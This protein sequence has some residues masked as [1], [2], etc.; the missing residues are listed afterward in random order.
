MIGS[1]ESS[2]PVSD[3]R[4]LAEAIYV[5]SYVEW[6]ILDDL[7]RLT[8]PPADLSIEG[9]SRS[10]MGHV[11]AA[12]RRASSGATNGAESAWLGA[13]ADALEAVV[14]RRNRVVHAHPATIA[15][16]QM[17]F[18]WATATPTKPHEAEAITQRDLE[19]L[20]DLAYVHLRR[21]KSVRLPA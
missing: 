20:R 12:V 6:G 13:A 8:N 11:A 3:M 10:T 18:R 2:P 19:A 16:S 9:L 1:F 17:L 21:V 14:D 7:P 5:V 4:A 15:D